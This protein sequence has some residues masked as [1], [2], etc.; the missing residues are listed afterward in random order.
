MC[1]GGIFMSIVTKTLQGGHM[2]ICRKCSEGKAQRFVPA[3]SILLPS[4]SKEI[5]NG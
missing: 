4:G 2:L 5:S 1:I 3:L